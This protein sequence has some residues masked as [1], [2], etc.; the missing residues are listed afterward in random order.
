MQNSTHSHK[1]FVQS[2]FVS[3]TTANIAGGN[4]PFLNDGTPLTNRG[5]TATTVLG[6]T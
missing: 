2:F 3:D 4:G 5:N 6:A 1:S